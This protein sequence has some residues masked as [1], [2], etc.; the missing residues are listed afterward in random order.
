M[1]ELWR[2]GRT[3]VPLVDANMRELSA[4]GFM[5]NRGRQ[6]V[7]SY[8][9]LDL[10]CDWRLG[11][12]WF[13][14]TLLDHDVSSNWGNWVA[15]AGL[16]GGRVNKFNMIKQSKDY[17]PE[18]L[19]IKAWLP[20]LQH[21]PAPYLF[22]P[23]NM[24]KKMQEQYGVQIGVDYPQA[25]AASRMARPQSDGRGPENKRHGGAHSGG[26]A[27]GGAQRGGRGKARTSGARSAM[28]FF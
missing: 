14:H 11:A 16:T 18:G 24:S 2:T 23:S 7:A 10:G 1:F 8:L 28:N 4:T 25:I 13:E 22:E 12:D 27:Q 9:V 15:A 17:D 5:S 6:N 21:V 20:E 19:Y 26:R 3:G